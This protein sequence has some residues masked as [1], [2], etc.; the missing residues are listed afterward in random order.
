MR[1][2]LWPEVSRKHLRFSRDR[3]VS[4]PLRT[5]ALE[6]PARRR[7]LTRMI[8]AQVPAARRRGRSHGARHDPLRNGDLTAPARALNERAVETKATLSAAA[9]NPGHRRR[10]LP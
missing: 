8:R 7:E 1:A 10:L 3:R 2:R 6:A 4:I 5:R 9:E